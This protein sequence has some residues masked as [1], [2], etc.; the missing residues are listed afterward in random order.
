MYAEI[1]N[2]YTQHCIYK[3][4]T[5]LTNKVIQC[6]QIVASKEQYSDLHT[7]KET[8]NPL[9]PHTVGLLSWQNDGIGVTFHC[10]CL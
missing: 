6:V 10:K 5:F 1:Q 8:L 3:I 7:L 2:V 4:F 9:L